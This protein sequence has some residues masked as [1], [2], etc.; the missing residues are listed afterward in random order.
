V[1]ELGPWSY[2]DASSP[3]VGLDRLLVHTELL[4]Q[5]IDVI[6]LLVRGN[7]FGELVLAQFAVWLAQIGYN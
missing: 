2:L 3:Q 5:G 7:E 6:A 4:R 1:R